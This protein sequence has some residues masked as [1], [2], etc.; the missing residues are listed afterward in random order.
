MATAG[1]ITG[2]GTQGDHPDW[3][4]LLELAGPVL[5]RWFMWMHEVALADGTA[6]QAYKHVATRRYLHLAGPERA[7]VYLGRDRYRE[8]EIDE[9]L[10]E[11]FLEWE[12]LCPEPD[13]D[14]LVAYDMLMARVGA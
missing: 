10:E 5:V 4:P 6:V 8:I 3:A 11:A 7:F 14:S 12:E 1:T 9:A 2:R 13:L